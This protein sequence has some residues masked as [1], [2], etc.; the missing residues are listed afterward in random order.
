MGFLNRS[1]WEALPANLQPLLR[2][3]CTEVTDGMQKEKV[4]ACAGWGGPGMEMERA[5]GANAS[6]HMHGAVLPRL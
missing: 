6:V 3:A 4:E 2:H 5:D 1:D